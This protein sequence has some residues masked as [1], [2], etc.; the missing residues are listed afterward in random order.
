MTLEAC[1]PPHLQGSSTI[2]RI[3]AGLS[4]AGVYRVEVA[5]QTFVLKVG[6]DTEP[7]TSWERRAR[8][9]AVAAEAGVAPLVVHVDEDRRAVLSAFVIDRSFPALYANPSTRER[10]IELLGGL[11]RRVHE[12]P[13]PP[14]TPSVDQRDVLASVWSKVSGA[15]TV[16]AFARDAIERVLAEKAPPQE[17]S[18]VLSH[19]DVNPTNLTYDGERL[20]LLDW[21]SA[22]ANDP[23]YD[24]AAISVF[25]RMDAAA[26]RALLEAHDGGSI[27]ELPARFAY[28]Q[29]FVAVFC[30]A[31]FLHLARHGGHAGALPE[32]TLEATPSLGDLYA[33]MRTGT[34]NVGSPAGQWAF[35]L[36]LIKESI[37]P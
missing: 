20:M 36:A 31:V 25:L 5:S 15:F 24:L 27:A 30:G 17:R 2:T 28:D 7:F 9:L 11:L 1:L 37:A 21:D 22:G 23:L 8:I 14:D 3:A 6:V 10:A 33:R 34:F 12:L 4:G 26:C 32:E 18:S 16:P 13:I 29:R 35:G 19:N